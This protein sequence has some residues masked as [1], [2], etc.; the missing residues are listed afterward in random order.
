MGLVP[1][2]EDKLPRNEML[3]P[4]YNCLRKSAKKALKKCL[5]LSYKLDGFGRNHSYNLSQG[6]MNISYE[7]CFLVDCAILSVES[8]T[9][10]L[11]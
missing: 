5:I 7:N 8:S 3:K 10:N 9:A 4:K 2:L 11:I 1:F 6:H